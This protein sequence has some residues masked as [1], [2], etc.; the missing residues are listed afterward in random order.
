MLNLET[1]TQEHN[2]RKAWPNEASDFTPWLADNLDYIGDI[3]GIDLELI[4]IESKVG[5]YS[6]DILAKESDT[7]NYIIIENQLEDSNHCHLGQL[8]TYASGKNAKAIVW[9]VKKAR[10]EHRNAIDWLNENTGTHLG[11]YLLEIELWY[12]GDASKLAPKFNVVE[13]PNEWAKTIKPSSDASSTQVLQLEFWQAFNDFAKATNFI[14]AFKLRPA[15]SHHWFDVS[16]GDSRCHMCLEAKNKK[17]E[18]TVGIYINNDKELYKSFLSHKSELANAM[19]CKESDITWT[20]S[21]SKKA[22]RFYLSKKIDMTDNKQ[23]PSI[24]NWYINNCL[25]IKKL[26]PSIL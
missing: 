11:F 6:A 2:L 10:E 16:I 7:E 21:D 14:K 1:L 19:G 12:I 17:G 4:E 9:V 20:G 24:F 3:L 18:A 13:Q 23:W 25:A 8:I 26:L 5:G 15:K 22:S